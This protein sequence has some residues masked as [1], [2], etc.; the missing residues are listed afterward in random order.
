MSNHHTSSCIFFLVPISQGTPVLICCSRVL[1]LPLLWVVRKHTHVLY[2]TCKKM[3][4]AC[5]GSWYCNTVLATP[6]L[7]HNSTAATTTYQA[8]LVTHAP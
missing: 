4:E 8:I 2:K 5:T 1:L 7:C 3:Y 6:F